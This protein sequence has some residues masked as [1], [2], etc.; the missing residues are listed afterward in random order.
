MQKQTKSLLKMLAFSLHFCWF[1]LAM[2]TQLIFTKLGIQTGQ[3]KFEFQSLSKVTFPIICH[4]QK[5]FFA[6]NRLLDDCLAAE[7]DCSI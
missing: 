4:P 1:S 2:P 3:E 5:L 6:I 7:L